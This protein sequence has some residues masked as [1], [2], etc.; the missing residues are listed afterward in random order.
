MLNI[1]KRR[2]TITATRDCNN[3]EYVTRDKLK[4]ILNMYVYDFSYTKKCGNQSDT[5]VQ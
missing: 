2:A 1:N 5:L 4:D 3:L